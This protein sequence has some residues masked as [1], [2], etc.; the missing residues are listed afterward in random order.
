MTSASS[1]AVNSNASVTRPTAAGASGKK[2]GRPPKNT[3]GKKKRGRPPTRKA[4]KYMDDSDSES[5]Y[6]D[7]ED[8]DDG[9]FP[10]PSKKRPNVAAVSVGRGAAPPRVTMNRKVCDRCKVSKGKK[11]FPNNAWFYAKGNGKEL[12]CYGCR[13]GRRSRS[14]SIG[15]TTEEAAPLA[16]GVVNG[17]AGENI[18][19]RSGRSDG[20]SGGAKPYCNTTTTNGSL[21][22]MGGGAATVATSA[23]APSISPS[24]M[25]LEAGVVLPWEETVSLQKEI[26][27]LAMRWASKVR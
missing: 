8:S 1:S 2:R 6:S 11:S 27:D 25:P 5:E 7:E 14:S 24:L 16:N 9:D 18:G 13:S 12:I 20:S 4:K 22:A 26:L 21:P 3:P 17:S 19:A 10:S 23:V 15:S